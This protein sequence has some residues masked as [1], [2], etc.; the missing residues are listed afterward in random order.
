MF[1][2]ARLFGSKNRR[3]PLPLTPRRLAGQ[4]VD[5]QIRRLQSA[6]G[7]VLSLPM[8][9]GALALYEWWRWLFSMPSNPLLLT[10][11]AAVAI[12]AAWRRRAVYKTE[13]RLLRLGRGEE[14][15]VAQAA[16]LLRS[17]AARLLQPIANIRIPSTILSPIRRALS[18]ANGLAK[19]LAA[20]W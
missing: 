19:R 10:I 13:L 4:S 14:P 18:P 17:T 6:W 1:L 5:E 12:H 7:D 16:A 15:T 2:P 9:L 20:R 11:V 3:T 8:C